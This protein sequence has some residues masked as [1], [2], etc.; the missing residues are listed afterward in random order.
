MSDEED[1]YYDENDYKNDNVDY[2][3]Y[4]KMHR[5]YLVEN[6][7]KINIDEIENGDWV[8]D[9]LGPKKNNQNVFTKTE[10]IQVVKKYWNI[11]TNCEI[12]TENEIETKT[13]TSQWNGYLVLMQNKL[14]TL[15]NKGQITS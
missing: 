1:Q 11:I 10:K 13:L 3:R 14:N 15:F 7:L 4:L 2:Y 6:I 12:M 9:R 8:N 5:D